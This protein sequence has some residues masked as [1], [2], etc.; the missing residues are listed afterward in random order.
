MAAFDA[1]HADQHALAEEDV[2]QDLTEQEDKDRSGREQGRTR[3]MPPPSLNGSQSEKRADCNTAEAKDHEPD[4]S[5]SDTSARPRSVKHEKAKRCEQSCQESNSSEYQDGNRS[6]H[7]RLC[8][9]G[10]SRSTPRSWRRPLC[11]LECRTGLTLDLISLRRNRGPVRE[12]VQKRTRPGGRKDM[13][14]R[15]LVVTKR[16]EE[17]IA[18]AY[19]PLSLI[20][21]LA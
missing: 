13:P 6:Y 18:V 10:R 14:G 11:S 5:G 2:N 4:Q 7:I 17:R 12:S 1:L 21:V 8:P 3:G 16:R 20:L 15:V 9:A 19:Q